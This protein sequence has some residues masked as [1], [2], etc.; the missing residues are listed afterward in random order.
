MYDV[1]KSQFKGTRTTGTAVCQVTL[2]APHLLGRIS[3]A[4]FLDNGESAK[5]E[6]RATHL[7]KNLEE[8]SPRLSSPPGF[9]KKNLTEV[10]PSGFILITVYG[11]HLILLL[12]KS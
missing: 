11:Y 5:A 8:I 7:R 4:D 2:E 3:Q 12:S 6:R 9:G 1:F 10:V